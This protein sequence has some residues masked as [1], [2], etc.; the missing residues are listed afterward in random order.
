M[1]YKLSKI[2][3][4][5]DIGP[6][7]LMNPPTSAP[8]SR[9]ILTVTL[10]EAIGLSVAE[11]YKERSNGEAHNHHVGRRTPVCVRCNYP[12][13]L[14]DYEKSQATLNCY[15]GT[16][17]N[18][19]WMS[20]LDICKFDVSSFSELA[21]YLYVRDPNHTLKSRDICLGVARANP[22]DELE[23]SEARWLDLE[24]GTGKLRISFEY[25]SHE[26]GTL[27]ERDLERD[28][29]I[30]GV[31]TSGIIKKDTQRVYAESKIRTTQLSSQLKLE[32]I[33]DYQVSHPFVAPLSFAFESSEGLT[34]LS[35]YISGG[36]LFSQL[37]KDRCFD[38]DR[39]RFYAAEITC[40][41][42]YLHNTR[43][44][45][46][47][48]KPRNALLDSFGHVVLCGFG[49]F[50]P[51]TK[52]GS[53]GTPEYPAPEFLLGQAE[54]R[55]ADWWTLGVFLYE[56]L[57]GLPPFYDEDHDMIHQ[58]ILTQPDYFPESFPP[59]AKDVITK[60]LDRDPKQRL[61][62][63]E[64]ASEVKSHPFFDGVDWNKLL[65]RKYTPTFRPEFVPNSF[66]QYRVN[67]PPKKKDNFWITSLE[68]T[69]APVA[70]NPPAQDS[71]QAVIRED[72]GWE[73]IWD[74]A[75]REFDLYNRF[76]KT[77][78]SVPPRRMR[79]LE[80]GKAVVNES[81]D[82]TVPSQTQ[83]EELLEAALQAGYDRVV[84]QL[85]EY[86]MDLNVRI[87]A[88][89]VSPLEWAAGEGNLPLVSLFLGKG[90]DA[91][92]PSFTVRGMHKG[93]PALVRAVEKGNREIAQAL[94][95][96][97]DR[98]ASTRA[99]GLAVYQQD[100]PMVKLLLENGVRCEFE[101]EDRPLPWDP[102]DDGCYFFDRAESE[103]FI[104]PLVR[105]VKKGNADLVRLLLLHGADVNAS[106]HGMLWDLYEF[107]LGKDPIWF[108]CGRPVELAMELGHDDI[109]GLLL[110]SDADINL[111]QP[112]W[113]V[114][115]HDCRLVPRL[116]YQ[117]VRAR[118]RAALASRHDGDAS[119]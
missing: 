8:S 57:T 102:Q 41:L 108:S 66:K 18:P 92:F 43:K 14:L 91:N 27:E 73:L 46:S 64:D 118:L 115:G 116:V 24:D 114:P 33:W 12:Y 37:Q 19:L 6:I 61:G 9:G 48:L 28:R 26:N 77:K 34:L 86:G 51:D 49:L 36:P 83:K 13:A 88:E 90:A 82:P 100:I 113:P 74:G 65:Q 54:S 50:N 3:N 2:S 22:F 67:N 95:R 17:E 96:T 107:D 10:H 69:K 93:G 117:K 81:A 63:N 39:S 80:H 103:E 99:L 75:R 71:H 16:T 32:S 4:E 42:E 97:T 68:S 5:K 55:T 53:H 85:L 58:K 44:V 70:S 52:S 79:P 111:P 35:P 59:S 45:F 1:S 56:M 38:V 20:R 119:V 72:D 84:L 110:D 112:S 106:Y 21:I 29:P 87:G 15:W 89:R 25:T 104:P 47:W 62:A 31:W 76:T 23:K 30:N 98:V 78:K 60:L 105:A 109:V 7:K 11:D 101:E 40:A 94:V